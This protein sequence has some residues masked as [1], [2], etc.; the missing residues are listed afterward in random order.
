MNKVIPKWI[1]VTMAVL[2]FIGFLDASYLAA[3]HYLGEVPD[4]SILKGCEIVT[5]SEYA[6]IL[7]VSIALLGALYYLAIFLGT[8]LY[9]DSKRA[10][11][12]KLVAL[13]PVAGF[14]FSLYLVYLM[15]FVL[16]AICL[17]CMGSATT[18]T[19]LFILSLLIFNRIRRS[20]PVREE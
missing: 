16:D 20:V 5:T 13:L 19:L 12:L 3:K 2:S 15:L 9:L 11:V 6:V 18:S 17:Y 8:V 7:G 14:A 10:L 4:C 1:P